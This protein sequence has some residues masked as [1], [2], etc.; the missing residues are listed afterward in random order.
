VAAAG[1]RWP[2]VNDARLLPHLLVDSAVLSV[3]QCKLAAG[4]HAMP[5]LP[6][7][8]PGGSGHKNNVLA[9]T[10]QSSC[11]IRRSGFLRGRKAGR[12][13]SE[14]LACM[15]R[16]KVMPHAQGLLRA[17]LACAGCTL[18]VGLQPAEQAFSWRCRVLDK[19]SQN[20]GDAQSSLDSSDCRDQYSGTQ[21]Q[22]AVG[23][24]ELAP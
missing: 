14:V 2:E 10:C 12:V 16:L 4:R 20:V 21:K 6:A 15:P 19:R 3:C 11:P 23:A 22:L 1:L 18:Q 5:K 9:C 13:C 8:L 17:K 24:V 7:L